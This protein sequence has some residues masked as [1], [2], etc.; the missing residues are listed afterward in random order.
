MQIRESNYTNTVD[1]KILQRIG[2]KYL[3]SDIG[4][5]RTNYNAD[6]FSATSDRRAG[7]VFGGTQLVSRLSG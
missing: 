4:A 1:D 5:A 2:R 3:N 7:S 6:R